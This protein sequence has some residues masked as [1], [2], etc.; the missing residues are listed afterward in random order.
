MKMS[1]V[2]ALGRLP[3]PRYPTNRAIAVLA[4]VVAIAAAIW[5]ILSGVAPL[6]SALWGIGAGFAL[7]LTWA[8]G[9]ELDPALLEAAGHRLVEHQDALRLRARREGAGWSQWITEPDEES[10]AFVSRMAL[11]DL[12]ESEQA[13]AI[14]EA[15]ADLHAEGAGNRSGRGAPDLDGDA[16]GLPREQ[17]P[18]SVRR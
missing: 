13:E 1:D 15:A 11:S 5:R 8:L 18:P 3:D 7:F 6:E 2:T 12:S 14:E 16:G 10:P 4:L 9:R 17:S